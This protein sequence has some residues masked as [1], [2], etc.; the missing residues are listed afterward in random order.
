MAFLGPCVT[1]KRLGEGA[2]LSYRAG[3]SAKPLTSTVS[4]RTTLEDGRVEAPLENQVLAP[5]EV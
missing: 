4:Q 5:I 2:G 3:Y 1:T